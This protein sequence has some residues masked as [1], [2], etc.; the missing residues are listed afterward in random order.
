MNFLKNMKI[1]KRLALSFGTIILFMIVLAALGIGSMANIQEHM[2]KI[3]KLNNVRAEAANLMGD[4]IREVS[5][6]L[7]NILLVKESS[8]REEQVGRI[9]TE[10]GKYD[11][12]LKKSGRIDS[13]D[14]HERAGGDHQG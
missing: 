14:R 1:G 6:S 8:K 7:R 10:R 3:V 12:A 9:A 11:A 5:I 13:Y 2:D 4:T